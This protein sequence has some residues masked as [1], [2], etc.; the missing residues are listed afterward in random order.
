MWRKLL[1]DLSVHMICTHLFLT[2]YHSLTRIARSFLINFQK[3]VNKNHMRAQPML[4]FLFI[5]ILWEQ[6]PSSFAVYVGHFNIF[7]G[8]PS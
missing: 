7:I 5:F 1:Y 2:V 8:F 6:T 3:R 4:L